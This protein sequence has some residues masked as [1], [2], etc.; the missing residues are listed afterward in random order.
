MQWL[1]IDICECL[2]QPKIMKHAVT[3]TSRDRA[4][5]RAML[6]RLGQSKEGS[7]EYRTGRML[8]GML[9]LGLKMD[10]QGFEKIEGGIKRWLEVNMAS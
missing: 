7:Q 3:L 9:M 5:A 8:R 4:R 6:E 1:G 10:I 2:D